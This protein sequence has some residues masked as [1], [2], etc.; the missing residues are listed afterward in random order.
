[1]QGLIGQLRTDQ[2]LF[3]SLCIGMQMSMSATFEMAESVFGLCPPC[4]VYK[5]IVI[6]L[7]IS[8]Y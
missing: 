6:A 1:M 7:G 8:V 5:Q 3:T 4:G 2:S